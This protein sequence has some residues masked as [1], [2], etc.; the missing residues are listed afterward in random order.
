MNIKK[1]TWEIVEAAKDND[2]ASW[3]FDVFIMLLIALNILASILESVATLEISYE[4]YFSVFE[5]FSVTIFTIEYL[6]RLWSCTTS[7]NYQNPVTGRIRFI[8]SPMSLIDLFAIGPFF[9]PFIG[10]DLRSLRALRLFRVLRLAKASRYSKS[11]ELIRRVVDARKQELVITT[12]FMATFLLASS[13]VLYFC[14]NPAQPDKFSSI[15]ATMWWAIATLTTVGY[16]DI[17]PITDLG[18]VCASVFAILGIGMFALPTGILGAGFVEEIQKKKT[19]IVCPHCKK[20]INKNDHVE[21][22]R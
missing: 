18:K 11:L 16:G 20:E 9:L 3:C 5:I 8:F 12:A 15:P 21:Q 13:T 17:Y 6:A 1:R 19:P 10:Y 22:S 14:E 2:R 7:P 4:Q